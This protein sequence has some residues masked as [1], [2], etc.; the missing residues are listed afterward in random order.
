MLNDL[1]ILHSHAPGSGKAG[2]LLMLHIAASWDTHPAQSWARS[3]E[4][5]HILMLHMAAAQTLVLHDLGQ[6]NISCTGNDGCDLQL[7]NPSSHVIRGQ[8][9]CRYWCC[10]LPPLGPSTYTV[11]GVQDAAGQEMVLNFASA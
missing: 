9:S 6:T 3:G 5:G 2:Q 4:A 7:P 10:T 11:M 8:M 1:F